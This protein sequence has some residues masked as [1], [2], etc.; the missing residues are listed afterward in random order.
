[1]KP[2]LGLLMKG[3]GYFSKYCDKVLNC[4]HAYTYLRAP[5]RYGDLS[6][7]VLYDILLQKPSKLPQVMDLK[8]YL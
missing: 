7:V 6:N 5:D 2:L 1:M 3:I 8:L 4:F